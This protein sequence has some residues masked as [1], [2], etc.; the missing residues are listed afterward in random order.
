MRL[1][2][3]FAEVRHLL[4]SSSSTRSLLARALYEVVKVHPPAEMSVLALPLHTALGFAEELPIK[5]REKMPQVRSALS[6]AFS[7][8]RL[9]VAGRL[10]GHRSRKAG[11]EDEDLHPPGV[12]ELEGLDVVEVHGVVRRQARE[13]HPR[14]GQSGLP[15]RGRPASLG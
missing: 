8:G 2:E 7:Q 1:R 3:N 9:R 12:A 11:H 10:L 6:S 14:V 13:V 15:A 4:R 5:L